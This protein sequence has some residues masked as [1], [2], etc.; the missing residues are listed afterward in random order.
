MKGEWVTEDQVEIRRK[1]S[2][3]DQVRKVMVAQAVG[4]VQAL[5][6]DESM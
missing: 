3:Q 2:T 6:V 4:M 1:M 5:E